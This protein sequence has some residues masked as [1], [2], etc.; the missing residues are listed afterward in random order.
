MQFAIALLREPALRIRGVGRMLDVMKNAFDG[1]G[2]QRVGGIQRR[3]ISGWLARK[4]IEA[5]SFLRNLDVL[6]Q[7]R[8]EATRGVGRVALVKAE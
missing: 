4:R 1:S 8:I 7:I 2:A 6:A 5:G 3:N